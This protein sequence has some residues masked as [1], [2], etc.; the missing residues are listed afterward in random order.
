MEEKGFLVRLASKIVIVSI[1]LVAAGLVLLTYTNPYIRVET[2]TSPTGFIGSGTSFTRTATTFTF[3]GF[4]ANFTGTGNFT[5]PG[6]AFSR[7]T[8][9]TTDIESITG[10]GLVAAGMI[11]EVFSLFL[12]PSPLPRPK[13][14]APS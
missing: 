9:T 12:R 10:L 14:E 3:T 6:G 8:L 2:G 13:V 5:R 1:V 11:L 7:T 4:P